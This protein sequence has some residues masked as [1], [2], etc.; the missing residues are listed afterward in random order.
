[1][2]CHAAASLFHLALLPRKQEV[3]VEEECLDEARLD[4]VRL[5]EVRPFDGNLQLY[6]LHAIVCGSSEAG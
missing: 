2:R 6:S 1:M 3:S 4:Q 5:D